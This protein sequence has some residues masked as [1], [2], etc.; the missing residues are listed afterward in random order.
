MKSTKTPT[1]F[2]HSGMIILI[3]SILIFSSSCQKKT[4]PIYLLKPGNKL[5]VPPGN[6]GT[7]Q[8]I[9]TNVN[10]DS[11][12]LSA[13]DSFDLDLNNDGITDF[14][15][16]RFSKLSSCPGTTRG[17][18]G[19]RFRITIVPADT[20][21]AIMTNGSLALSLDSSTAISPDSVWA[22]TSQDL[23]YGIIGGG[24][25]ILGS[26]GYWINVSDKYLGLK[27]I[28]DNKTYYGWA[29]LSSSFSLG[30]ERNL[31]AGGQ[32]ILK[33]YAYN[34]I[35]GQPIDAGQTK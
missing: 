1:N 9:Y 16:E 7:S 2:S 28:K 20:G 13:S 26:G 27:F 23:L 30:L 6:P 10:P 18:V 17:V 33:D 31:I 32:L 35:P 15:L 3:I 21:N 14:V 12:I 22:T 8:I 19:I 34:N 5:P 4:I 29:R 24:Q 25:C 11:V